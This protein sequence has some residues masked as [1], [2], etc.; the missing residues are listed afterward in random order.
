MCHIDWQL[1]RKP[2]HT[3]RTVSHPATPLPL[4]LPL[5]LAFIVTVA[6]QSF[7]ETLSLSVIM[8]LSVASRRRFQTAG[9]ANGTSSSS[10]SASS[11]RCPLPLPASVRKQHSF[12]EPASKY[13]A[14]QRGYLSRG[15]SVGRSIENIRQKLY[16]V[17]RQPNLAAAA[18]S[19]Q[20]SLRL[21]EKSLVAWSSTSSLLKPTLDHHEPEGHT[22]TDHADPKNSVKADKNR[23]NLNI[24]LAQ[25]IRATNEQEP[26]PSDIDSA[27]ESG[28]QPPS[29]PQPEPAAAAH[30]PSLS[31]SPTAL[32]VQRRPPLVRAMSAPVRGLDENSKSVIAASK[33]SQQKLRRRKIF[34]RTGSSVAGGASPPT[35]GVE[36]SLLGGSDSSKKTLGRTRSVV[37][38][39]VITLVSLLSSEG[40]DSERED[41]HSANSTPGGGGDKQPPGSTQRSPQRRAPLLR[42]TGKSDSYPPT[43]Q[44]ASKEYSHMIRRGSIAPLAARIRANRPPTAPPVSIFL[45]EGS[46]KSDQPSR[47]PMQAMQATQGELIGSDAPPSNMSP[48]EA[49][50]ENNNNAVNCSERQDHDHN[51][52]LYVRSI[53]ERE[54]WKLYQKMCAKGVSVS[55]DTVLRGMLTPTEFR[56]FQKQREQEEARVQQ[57]AEAAEAA[58][59]AAALEASEKDARKLPATAIERLSESLLQSK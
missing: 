50:K 22:Q 53:K 49:K 39:D 43:F 23:I 19:S 52:P 27:T 17:S 57:E 5:P 10:R 6:N 15:L 51:Y 58:A 20:S 36:G 55:Y 13:T 28:E 44:L 56:H 31:V 16:P 45:S 8:S 33:R 11:A 46:A 42:K 25:T 30:G 47:K 7:A 37:A 59:A 14:Q 21:R 1:K 41:S 48:E 2:N 4:P 32:T 54:C 26:I 12:I 24:V 29:R 40:S 18:A 9:T 38:P 35:S 34:T 3:H